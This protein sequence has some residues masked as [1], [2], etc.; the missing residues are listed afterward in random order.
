MGIFGKK[1]NKKA[2]AKEA[3][4]DGVMVEAPVVTAPSVVMTSK[5]GKQEPLLLDPYNPE[6]GDTDISVNTE[7][8][9][10]FFQKHI[11]RKKQRKA[12]AAASPSSERD[13]EMRTAVSE[14]SSILSPKRAYA[15]CCALPS[16][17]KLVFGG[18]VAAALAIGAM[19]F[20]RANIEG[21]NV[22]FAGNSY[23]LVNDLPRL[24]ETMANG[25]MHQD[26]C[27]HGSGSP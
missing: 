7:Y 6:T 8:K 11:L 1:K 4:E 12:A 27:L 20:A 18:A 13:Y 2:K 16:A 9:E 22:A 21:Q 15:A 3:I 5:E 14:D 23:F 25:Q 26:S 19:N 24:M 17:V 10:T